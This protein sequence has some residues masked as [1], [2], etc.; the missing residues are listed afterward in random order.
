MMDV[1]IIYHANCK[2]GI[3]SKWILKK[4]YPGAIIIEMF[5]GT[6]PPFLLIKN[7][8]VV[9][10]DICFSVGHLRKVAEVVNQL[11]V[12]DH[13]QTAIDS[14][15]LFV[16]LPSNVINLCDDKLSGCQLAWKYVFNDILPPP[17]IDYIGDN[18]RWIHTRPFI[19]EVMSVI[20]R[21][22]HDQLIRALEKGTIEEYY[23]EGKI[24]FDKFMIEVDKVCEIAYPSIVKVNSR[25]YRVWVISPSDLR[26]VSHACSKLC[27]K[28]F[29]DG[30]SP[31]FA[32]CYNS[33]TNRVGLRSNDLSVELHK[34]APILGSKG[35]GHISSAAFTLSKKKKLED[36]FKKIDF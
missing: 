21:M 7:K 8:T 11:I 15:E 4:K 27:S 12:L 31:D 20:Y 29:P 35:G 6:D 34:I 18:D 26:V 30:N 33:R 24:L 19:N 32:A 3:A 22:N 36:V 10:A 17:I 9:L 16:P 5:S 23:S 13:H 28:I 14:F 1:V 2:D 25:E